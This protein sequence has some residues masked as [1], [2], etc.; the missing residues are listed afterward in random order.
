MSWQIIGFW[1]V[2]AVELVE[3]PALVGPAL[4]DLSLAA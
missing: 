4:S 1:S 2:P 3:D